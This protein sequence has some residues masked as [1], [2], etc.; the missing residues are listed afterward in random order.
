MKLELVNKID[1]IIEAYKSNSKVNCER[2]TKILE[3][4]K[5]HSYAARITR[6]GLQAEIKEQMDA[7][8]GEWKNDDIVSHQQMQNII[9]KAKQEVMKELGLDGTVSRPSDYAQRISNAIAFVKEAISDIEPYEVAGT[10]DAKKA[11]E[12]DS[13]LHSILKDFIGDYDTM[14]LFKKMIEKKIPYLCG[15]DGKTIFPKTLG[16]FVKV[17]SIMNTIDELEGAAENIF[18]H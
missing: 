2:I 14:K 4:Y 9:A 3:V 12:I 16:S 13:D 10:M 8:V 1:E 15:Y 6:E 18:I 5:V 17:E 11:A 7:I